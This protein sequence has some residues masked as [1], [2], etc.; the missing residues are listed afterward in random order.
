MEKWH[1]ISISVQEFLDDRKASGITP[2]T[3]EFYHHNL[4]IFASFCGRRGIEDFTQINP[5]TL[6]AYLNEEGARRTKGGTHLL[7]RCVRAYLN[8]CT[9]EYELADWKN[10]IRKIHGLKQPTVL[11]D[12]VSPE[13]VE[14]LVSSCNSK[15]FTDL[16]D[17]ALL[18]FLLDTGLRASE[19]LNLNCD[20]LNLS[21]RTAFVRHGKGDKPRTVIFGIAVRKV[22]R[23]YLH[24]VSEDGPV[25][26]T[27]SG[28]RLT[29]SGMRDILRT[30]SAEVAVEEPTLHSFRR[31]F[32][33]NC[34]RNG[35]DVFSLQNLMGHADLQILRVYLKQDLGDLKN[36]HDNS[37][38]VDHLK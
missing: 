16:R 27:R 7:Y 34:L 23:I 9:S 2:G 13:I 11:L 8:F 6:R 22:L 21:G 31:A 35:M 28:K 36:A 18:L 26:V 37:S 32:A 33:I 12:P 1:K 5:E 30:R 38:P 20:D 24:E 4:E 10:P 25:W 3:L 29:Y 15:S 17:K 19:C 14:K